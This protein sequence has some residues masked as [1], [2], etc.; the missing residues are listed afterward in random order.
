MPLKMIVAAAVVAA[1]AVAV[2][3]FGIRD[4]DSSSVAGDDTDQTVAT[5]P[6]TT[7]APLDDAGTELQDLLASSRD[8]T[9]HA[10]YEATAPAQTEGGVAERYTVDI[11]RSEGRTRQDTATQLEG[12]D[13]LTAGIL[14]DGT[15][16]VCAKQGPQDWVCSETEVDDEEA[17]D[18]IFGQVIDDLG[19]VTVTATDETIDGE[20][21]RCFSYETSDGP[22][23]MC[24]NADGVPLR[25]TGGQTSL[26]LTELTEE[27]DE[28]VFEPPAEPMRADPES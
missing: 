21:A 13:Y 26:E 16:I 7:G 1:A 27:V 2:W 18:G 4:D 9:F 12:G 6:P 15:S 11:Y 25:I 8:D 28:S 17:S 22:G 10:T 14:V 5:A 20:A 23:S 3:F 24:L 19:G